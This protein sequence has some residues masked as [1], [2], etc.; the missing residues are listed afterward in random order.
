VFLGGRRSVRSIT[1]V[2]GGAG[3]RRG[4]ANTAK[5]RVEAAGA[6]VTDKQ[7]AIEDL[8]AELADEL[9]DLAAGW[10]EK[11]AN[12]EPVEIPLEKTDVRVSDLAVVWLPVVSPA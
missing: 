4:R 5:T 10:D 2:L 3:S 9:L 12:V 1:N 8:E 6:R 7:A 11:A